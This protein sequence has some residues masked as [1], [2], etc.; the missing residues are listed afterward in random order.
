MLGIYIGFAVMWIYNVIADN[1]AGGSAP[2][3]PTTSGIG[4]ALPLYYKK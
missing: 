2:L 3:P 4:G 1:S